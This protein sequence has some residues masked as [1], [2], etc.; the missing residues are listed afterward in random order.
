[1]PIWSRTERRRLGAAL[2][3][4][5]LAIAGPALA[6]DDEARFRSVYRELVE[7][8]TS[9]STGSCTVAAEKMA[10]RLRAAGYSAEEARLVVPEA[11]PRQGNLVVRAA[12]TDRSLE[13][14][15]FLAHIDVVEA[16][17]SDWKRDPFKLVEEKGY[18]FARGAVDD[19][20]MAAA[21][22]DALVR[23]REEGFR[24]KRTIK[25]ALTCGE[26]TDSVFNGVQ[27]LLAKEPEALRAAFAINEGGKA[28][29]DEAGNYKL[30]G[31]EAGQ[32]VYQDFRLV[33]TAPGG[34]SARPVKDNAI[35]RLSAALVRV[36]DD[37][38]PVELIDASRIFFGRSAALYTGQMRTDMTA[39]GGGTADA[40]AFARIGAA[41]PLWNAMLRTTCAVTLVKGG[42]A[43]NALPQRAEANVNC[44]LLPG[45]SVESTLE[46]LKSVVNDA[47]VEISL[48]APP[49]PT[50]PP[51]PLTPA[52]LGPIEAT[53]AEVWPGVPVI[54][55]LSTGATD[56]R[57]LTAAGI[58]TF[59]VSGM[60][61][62]PDGNGVHGLDERIRV[63]SLIEGRRFL[64]GLMKS[65]A[66]GAAG[67]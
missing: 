9:L 63:R 12:G 49:G 13:P 27:Y 3:L 6:A 45:Q 55:S 37:A 21:F 17:R 43:E 52:V 25:V 8:D 46:R 34:H 7:T 24:P 15:L 50:S 36:N 5:G 26:E 59:G 67:T 4:A 14:V 33:T 35:A 44:R 57:F 62:D 28:L 47:K 31:V 10:A 20:A 48:G 11:F 42:H 54:P 60:F 61:V 38:F 56:G 39:I 32:K 66:L 16:K 1:L 2:L 65:F 53:A 23:F 40:A 19:K 51:P 58:P 30:V 64:Y 29:L 22:V 18:F 41:D